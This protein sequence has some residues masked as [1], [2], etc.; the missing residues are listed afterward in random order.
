MIDYALFCK[1]NH[2]SQNDGLTAQQIARELA[3]DVRTIRKW[4]AET[5]FKPRQSTVR[6][7]KLD[8]FQMGYCPPARS[9]SLYRDTDLST[10]P[11][12]KVLPASI[13]SSRTTSAK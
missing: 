7:S 6:P 1:I 3:M 9:P 10:H 4:V 13:P 5:Q 12:N 8:P 11:G 2:L